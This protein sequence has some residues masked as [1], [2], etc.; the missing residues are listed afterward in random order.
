MK[1]HICQTETQPLFRR[2][3]LKKYRVQYFRCP[4]CRFI[5]TEEPHWLGGA[6]KR[7]INIADCG[8]LTRNMM[9]AALTT[10]LLFPFFDRTGKF[11]DYS[12]GF[13]VLTRLM[14]D[15]G[16]DFYWN[17]PYTENLFAVG[18]EGQLKGKYE[19][20][21]SFEVLEHLPHPMKD[22]QKIFLVTD[23]LIFSTQLQPE[24][25]D[26]WWY[27]GLDHGQHVSLYHH[28]TLEEIA[29][30]LHL[31]LYSNGQS[32]HILTRKMLPGPIVWLLMWTF[33]IVFWIFKPFLKSKTF[34][35][36]QSLLKAKSP[37]VL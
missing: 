18:F 9:L 37:D 8:L 19:V 21:T 36:S 11:L 6:Y 35:D 32:V 34:S 23:T 24:E 7:P 20:I 27:F 14:R 33:P 10:C 17:D 3:V 5:Q 22:L 28:A 31:R 29:R 2:K 26:N 1:C 30:R 16:F 13:G 25:L 4:H 12:G 15:V